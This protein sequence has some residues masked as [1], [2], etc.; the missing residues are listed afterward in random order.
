MSKYTVNFTNNSSNPGNVI[1]FQQQPE[2][3]SADIYSLAWFAKAANKGVMVEF[4]WDV[5]YSFVWSQTGNVIPGVIFTASQN[6]AADPIKPSGNQITLLQND[7]GLSFE[8]QTTDRDSQGSLVIQED[9]T[10]PLGGAAVG[11]GMSGFGTFVKATGPNQNL[12]FTPHPEYWIAFGNYEQGEIL[13]IGIVNNPAQ[14]AFP[15][16]HSTA[17]ATLNLDNSWT[18]TYL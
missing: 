8:G 10:V 15:P 2:F 12:I 7:Y 5:N 14:I 18:I 17:N 3:K 13:D 6:I 16:G 11:I 9:G 4:D 1:L